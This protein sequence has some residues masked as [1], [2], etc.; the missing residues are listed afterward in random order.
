MWLLRHLEP[1]YRALGEKKKAKSM[2]EI[3]Q[4]VSVAMNKQLWE[5]KSNDHYVTSI[6]PKTGTVLD[7][8][9]Y[10]ANLIAVVCVT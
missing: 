9:D 7:M 5:T 8:V 3:A 4:A 1:M 10:D 6:D 2:A